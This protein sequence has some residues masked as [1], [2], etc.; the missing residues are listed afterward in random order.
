MNRTKELALSISMFSILFLSCICSCIVP[1][2]A[3]EEKVPEKGLTILD[4]VIGLDL[5]KYN[6]IAK[7]YSDDLYFDTLP[8]ERIH[9]NLAGN[10]STV[11]MF[12]TFVNGKLQAIQ[13]L[14]TEGSLIL[15]KPVENVLEMTKSFLDDYSVQTKNSLYE[16][17]ESSLVSVDPNKNVTSIIG[18]TKLEVTTIKDTTTYRWTYTF[19]GIEAPDKYVA[20]E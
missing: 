16:Q 10:Q 1:V 15:N 20:L 12:Q 3:T 5:T 17:L 14:K 11:D 7:D 18:N 4:A 19:D 6:T 2:S 9:L 13:V 8:Q